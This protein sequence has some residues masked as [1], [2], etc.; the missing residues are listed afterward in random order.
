MERIFINVHIH[1]MI[2]KSMLRKT[3]KETFMSNWLGRD[4][5]NCQRKSHIKL[6]E[7]NAYS[8]LKPQELSSSRYILVKWQKC[9]EH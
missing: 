6:V 3:K 8:Y 5:S 9:R 7:E 1:S 2:C 4:L